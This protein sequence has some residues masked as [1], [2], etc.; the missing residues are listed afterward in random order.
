MSTVQDNFTDNSTDNFTTISPTATDVAELSKVD[1]CNRAAM[2]LVSSNGSVETVLDLGPL[3]CVRTDI[4]LTLVDN[5]TF[6]EMTLK[7]IEDAPLPTDED[8][9]CGT[10][11]LSLR[12][13]HRLYPVEFNLISELQGNLTNEIPGNHLCFPAALFADKLFAEKG[14]GSL[15]ASDEFQPMDNM[16]I[17][18]ACLLV[19]GK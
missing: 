5:Q 4:A 13:N 14:N 1:L 17:Y 19:E 7:Y 11:S 3:E 8:I 9:E 6:S 16:T 18:A 10:A 12:A 15:N 2:S